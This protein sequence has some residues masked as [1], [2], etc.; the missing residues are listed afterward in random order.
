MKLREPLKIRHTGEGRCPVVLSCMPWALFTLCV[1]CIFQLD[2]GL[3]RNDERK[4]NLPHH[5]SISLPTHNP[6]MPKTIIGR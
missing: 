1:R 6:R 5:L 2:S 4:L 3:R